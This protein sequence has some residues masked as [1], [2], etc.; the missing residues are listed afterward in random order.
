MVVMDVAGSPPALFLL[1]GKQFP[2]Q[3]LQFD[4][5]SLQLHLMLT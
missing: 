1:R 5:V 3:V 2:H 4:P